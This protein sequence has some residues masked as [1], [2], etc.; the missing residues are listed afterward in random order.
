MENEQSQRTRIFKIGEILLKENVITK[1]QLAY[2][3]HLQKK[4]SD[5]KP[6]GE[7]AIELG[8]IWRNDFKKL[9]R[10]YKQHLRIGELFIELGLIGEEQ[11]T[12]ALQAQATVV[13]RGPAILATV[14]GVW[15][16]GQTFTGAVD[17]DVSVYA[18][19]WMPLDTLELL[20]NGAVVQTVELSG[21]AAERGSAVFSLTPPADAHYIV[22][23]SGAASMHPV[24]SETA[25]AMTAALKV[26]VAGDGWEA[27]LPALTVA[28]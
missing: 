28:R 10:Q 25:W 6:L 19:S 23:A 4:R 7:L 14:G 1:K 12:E 21:T 2:M 18:P 11:L 9:L 22:I 15:A 27:P 20:E 26:D 8:Y 16:P 24:Y 13:S 3:L 5:W 17:L